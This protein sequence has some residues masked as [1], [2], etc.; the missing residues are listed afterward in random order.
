MSNPKIDNN[1]MHVSLVIDK[2]G[3]M[4][5][6]ENSVIKV[7]DN[8]IQYL[9]DKSREWNHEIRVSIYLFGS[10]VEV[11]V[12]EK[13]VL[14]LPSVAQYYRANGN[15]RLMD[16]VGMAIEDL[17]KVPEIHANHSFVCY[18]WTDGEENASRNYNSSKLKGLISALPDNYTV[19]AFVPDS[20][21]VLSC[22]QYGIPAGNISIWDT[23]AK[24]VEETGRIIRETTDALIKNQQSGAKTK[25]T[26]LFSLNTAGLNANTV[27]TLEVLSSKDYTILQV[28]KDSPIKEFV[29]SWKMDFRQGANYYQLTKKEKVQAN[30]CICIQEKSTGKVYSGANA[31]KI[32]GLPD[33]EV[34]IEAADHPKYNIFIQST[35]VNR[36]LM[37]G[38]ELLVMI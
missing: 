3:S 15:T 1:I 29:E 12:Y 6:L 18:V 36:K 22:K 25:V 17:R 19:G 38:T 16:G 30:K 33:Y 5:N 4:Q 24:G 37:A 21:G 31:R 34:K 7:V 20:N 2:S 23:S 8:Q 32:L 11:L 27:K 13:D 26:N 28:R 9:A 10:D 35:S 14:R